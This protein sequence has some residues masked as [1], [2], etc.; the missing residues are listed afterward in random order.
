LG[1]GNNIVSHVKSV[2][3]TDVFY[4]SSNKILRSST[5]GLTWYEMGTQGVEQFSHLDLVSSGGNFVCAFALASDG[6]VLKYEGEPFAVDPN[7]N[8]IPVNYYLEQ[9]YPN[10]FNPVTVI[11]YSIPLSG[12]VELKIFDLSGR[13]VLDLVDTYQAAGSYIEQVDLSRFSSGVYYYNFSSG[14]FSETRKMVLIK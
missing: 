1:A 9:N 4:I 3:G 8:G 6:R 12:N 10:P 14:V 2:P 5:N 11:R 13:K 7:Q